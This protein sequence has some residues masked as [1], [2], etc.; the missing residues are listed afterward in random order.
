ML[1]FVY[2]VIIKLKLNI[3][4]VPVMYTIRTLQGSLLSI[5]YLYVH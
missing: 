3:K 5:I 4:I 2:D 1:Y